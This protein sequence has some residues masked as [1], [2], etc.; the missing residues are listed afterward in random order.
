M[1]L[2]S[3]RRSPPPPPGHRATIQNLPLPTLQYKCPSVRKS[4]NLG[5]PLCQWLS[6]FLPATCC[7]KEIESHKYSSRNCLR[8]FYKLYELFIKWISNH[9]AKKDQKRWRKNTKSLNWKILTDV[10]LE[11]TLV[12]NFSLSEINKTQVQTIHLLR[13]NIVKSTC[14][15]IW[16]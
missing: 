6:P 12:K 16:L 13:E 4:V 7:V 15:I 2:S 8:L 3:Y 1:P 11:E 10:S 14:I 5:F 9:F